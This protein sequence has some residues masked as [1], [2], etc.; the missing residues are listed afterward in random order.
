MSL[1]QAR[2]YEHIF[3]Q[4]G[5]LNASLGIGTFAFSFIGTAT[6]NGSGNALGRQYLG[7]NA[8]KFP[9]VS[10]LNL[11]VSLGTT[12]A[13]AAETLTFGLY[14]VDW[15]GTTNQI[16]TFGTVIAGSTIVFATPGV[17]AELSGTSTDFTPPATDTYMIGCLVDDAIPAGTNTQAQ[18]LLRGR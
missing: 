4:V 1:T 6:A 16:P 9:G 12:A 8:A 13:L 7:W 5:I 2:A 17:N 18:I 11:H 14:P 10:R 3:S 15:S